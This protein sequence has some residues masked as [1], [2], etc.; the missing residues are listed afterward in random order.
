MVRRKKGKK[1]GRPLKLRHLRSSEIITLKVT[2]QEKANLLQEA[3][4]E[5]I[6]VSA[7]LMKPWRT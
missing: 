1:M 7:V 6:S 4:Q 3:K 2:E 5:G